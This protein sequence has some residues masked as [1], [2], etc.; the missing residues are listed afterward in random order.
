MKC[1]QSYFTVLISQ[2][3]CK[4]SNMKVKVAL[5]IIKLSTCMWELVLMIQ[6]MIFDIHL[7]TEA[8]YTSSI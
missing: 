6:K 3:I 1:V 7:N 5:Y 4:A 8:R 2:N